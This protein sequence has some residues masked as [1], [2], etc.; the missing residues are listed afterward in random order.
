MRSLQDEIIQAQRELTCPICG[1]HFGIK[2]IRVQPTFGQGIVEL[3]VSCNREH[4]PVILLVP[5]NLKKLIEAGPIRRKELKLAETRIDK[6][7]D[8]QELVKTK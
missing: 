6:I 5:V 2:D 1:R 4:F 8:I 7:N 3:A